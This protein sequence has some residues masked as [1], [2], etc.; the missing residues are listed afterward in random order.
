MLRHLST[1]SAMLATLM[2]TDRRAAPEQRRPDP[3]RD[4]IAMVRAAEHAA[5]RPAA[6][7]ER[8]VATERPAG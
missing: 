4:V 2:Q 5:P 7:E 6:A 3:L 1:G 8:G